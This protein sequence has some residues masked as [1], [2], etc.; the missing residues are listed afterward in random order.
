MAPSLP[1][2][3]TGR[4]SDGFAIVSSPRRA[5]LP[6]NFRIQLVARLYGA[7]IPAGV[8]GTLQGDFRACKP[9]EDGCAAADG[10]RRRAD[11]DERADERRQDGEKR[12]LP[13]EEGPPSDEE[14]D[15]LIESIS[16]E[17]G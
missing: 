1:P 4:V 14:I 12:P 2:N 17:N 10:D 7:R 16:G 5:P 13:P 3:T 8:T 9:G 11:R 15:E 6:L